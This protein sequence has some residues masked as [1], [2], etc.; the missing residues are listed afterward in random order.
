MQYPTT[1]TR[2]LPERSTTKS[3]APDMSLAAC[4]MFIAIISLPAPSGSLAVLPW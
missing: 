4:A 3:T 1:P 2:S